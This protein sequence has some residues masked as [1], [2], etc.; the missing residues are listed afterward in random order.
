MVNE[1]DSNESFEN[2]R[3]KDAPE[4]LQ[5][6]QNSSVP[7]T[8]EK[9]H[10]YF[11]QKAFDNKQHPSDM[12]LPALQSFGIIFDDGTTVTASKTD[13]ADADSSMRKLVVGTRDYKPDELISKN[14]RHQSGYLADIRVSIQE[15]V[16]RIKNSS[17]PV[18]NKLVGI[19]HAL[20]QDPVRWQSNTTGK[21]NQLVGESIKNGLGKTPWKGPTPSCH[22]MIAAFKQSAE[23][24]QVWTDKDKNTLDAL[25]EFQAFKPHQGDVVIW[26]NSYATHAAIL[27]E[28][29]KVY[30]AG[31]RTSK[32]GYAETHI[33]NYTGTPEAP[34]N[35]GAP[36]YIFRFKTTNH[37]T[38]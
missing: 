38:K 24:Q 2:R 32:T 14:D 34:M 22:G 4:T 7:N 20:G 37:S 36:T 28:E 12:S 35:Y 10:H 15:E 21:C 29:S 19:A 33:R 27:D 8:S 13:T 30:Y 9:Q 1:K 18:G 17:A 26:D 31:S 3:T 25:K 5:E 11:E 23:W 16:E 6:V